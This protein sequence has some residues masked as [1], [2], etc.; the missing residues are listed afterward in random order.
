GI[1]NY[2][3]GS[4]IPWPSMTPPPGYF[5]MAGQR[6]SCGLYPQLARAYPGCVLPDLRGVFIRGLD[7]ERGLDPGRAILSFQADQSNM[8]ASYGGALRGHHRGMTY[9]YPGGQEV[10]PKNVAFNYIVKAG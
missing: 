6:F 5:L 7:N 1:D 9:Y 4:P 10:R 2:P 8:I 3:I